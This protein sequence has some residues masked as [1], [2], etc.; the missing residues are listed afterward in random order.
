MRLLS[1]ALVL[2]VGMPIALIAPV[3]VAKTNAC[4]ASEGG[5]DL[6]AS[7]VGCT[8]ARDVERTYYNRD[9]GAG[10]TVVAGGRT[11]RCHARILKTTVT[12]PQSP[13]TGSQGEFYAHTS[14]AACVS[15]A[16]STTAAAIDTALADEHWA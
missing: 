6:R 14:R 2:V 1:A 5:F 8:T 16:G 11:W 15:C 10:A 9:L 3:A 13:A 12:T 7:M 4:R